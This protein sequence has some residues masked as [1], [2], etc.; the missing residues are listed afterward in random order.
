[1]PQRLVVSLGLGLATLALGSLLLN[2]VG[3]LRA[4]PWALFAVLV[5]LADCRY[6]AMVRP[7][8]ELRPQNLR[9]PRLALVPV[10]TVLAGLVAAGGAVAV[11]FHPVQADHAV[12]FSE[13]YLQAGTNP[14]RVG[15]GVGNQEHEPTK[16]GLIVRFSGGARQ[17]VRRLELDP[18]QNEV[19]NVPVVGKRG[20]APVRVVAT[21]YREQEPN[22]PYRVV[23]G[24]VPARPAGG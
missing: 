3:G 16:Y 22:Q 24:S 11:A 4:L 7:P 9:L 19:V 14:D 13:L 8:T 6:A 15:I 1:M 10:L 17:Q 20:S 23:S 2:Y 5:V 12:G 18:G 21:L